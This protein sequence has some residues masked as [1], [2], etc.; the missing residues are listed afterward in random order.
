MLQSRDSLDKMSPNF[1][2]CLSQFL[3]RLTDPRPLGVAVSGGSDSL[4]LLYGLA[5]LSPP[6]KLVALT[7]DHGLREASADEARRVKAHCRRLGIRHET[8]LWDD[9]RPGS[10]IQAAARAARYHLMGS[11]AERLGL[12]AVLTGHTLDDQNETLAMRRTR[13][14]SDTAPGMAGIPA[15][16]LFGGHMWVL[17]PVLGVHRA[18]IR[19]FLDG[20]SVSW[21]DDPSN[22]D[23]R[24]ERVRVRTHLADTALEPGLQSDGQIAAM[25]A[26]LAH[27]AASY[28]DANCSAETQDLVRM[29]FRREED[30][31]VL[32]AVLEALIDLCGGAQ[33]SLDRRGKATLQAAL[34]GWVGTRSGAGPGGVM[35]L[36]RTLIKHRGDE[37]LIKREQRGIENL[38]LQPKASAVWDGRYRVTNL[39]LNTELRVSAFRGKAV[40]PFFG[41]DLGG[42]QGQWEAED[43]VVGGFVCERLIGRSSKILPVHELVLAQALARMVGSA[44]FPKC[45]VIN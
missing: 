29:Q 25:R 22:T 2:H 12:A 44:A 24:F 5:S 28:I 11:V 37:V 34:N 1:R 43:G 32:L 9:P 8:L 3:S 19:Q 30:P 10:G 36:G 31:E 21:I 17:R 26:D 35:T 15:A 40:A 42:R 20:S 39:D 45:P 27:K 23:P 38:E 13:S 4:G 6:N 16:T 14:P 41:R 18:E 33:R 7:V